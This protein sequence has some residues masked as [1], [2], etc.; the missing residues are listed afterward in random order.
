[1]SVIRLLLL[2]SLILPAVPLS[3]APQSGPNS[4]KECSMCHFRWIDDFLSEEKKDFLLEF[5][6]ERVVASEMMCYSCHDGS[7]ADSRFRVWETN[8]HKAGIKPSAKVGIPEEYPL[9]SEGRIQCATCHTAHGV[10]TRVDMASAIFLREPNVNSS[11]CKRCHR[12]KDDGVDEGNHPVDVEFEALPQKILDA[13]AKAGKNNRVICE[14]CHTAHGSTSENFLVI[15]NSEATL[16][17]SLL[18]ETCHTVAPDISSEASLR[19]HSHPVDLEL[20][21]EASLPEHWYNGEVPYLGN[22]VMVNCRTCHSPHNGT[23]KNHLLVVEREGSDRLCMTCHTS[24]K[25]ILQTKHDMSGFYPEEKNA[26]GEKASEIGVCRSCH[27]MHKGYGPKMWARNGSGIESMDDLCL[28]CHASGKVAEKAQTGDH[29]HPTGVGLS[30]GV[31]GSDLPL[32]DSEG[33]KDPD[34]KVA[35]ASCHDVHQWAPDS[36]E[37]GGKRVDGD[38]LSSF[39]RKEAAQS[40]ELCQSCHPRQMAI[41]GTEHDLELTAPKSKNINKQSLRRSGV[42]GACHLIHNAT[43]EKLWARKKGVGEDVIEQLCNGCHSKGHLAEEKTTGEESHPLGDRA[44]IQPRYRSKLPLHTKSGQK[45][46][47]GGVTCASC[48]DLH[49]WKPGTKHGPGEKEIEG[50]RFNSFLRL[51]NDDKVTLCAACH[52][53]NA[54]VLGT[55]HDLRITAPKAKNMDRLTTDETGVCGTCHIVHNAWGNNLWS[56]SVGPG[57]NR[58]EALCDGCHARRQSASKKALHGPKHP[59]NKSVAEARGTLRRETATFYQQGAD[60]VLPLFTNEGVR[61]TE[62][63]ITCSTCHNPHRWDPERPAPTG[64]RN[65]EGDGGNSFLRKSNLPSSGLCTLCHTQKANVVKTEHDMNLLA[66]REKNNLKQ[67]VAQSGVCSACHVPHGAMKGG[68]LLWSRDLGEGSDLLPEKVCLSCHAK[69]KVGG[70]KTVEEF[71]HPGEV[72]VGESTRQQ[73]QAYVPIYDEKGN[74]ATAGVITCPTCHNPHDWTP[75]G[76]KPGPGEQSEGSSR[77]S[78]LRF[79]SAKS[80]CRDCHGL[81]SLGRYKYYHHKS[82]RKGAGKQLLFR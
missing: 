4:S 1:M 54:L 63:D 40:E 16:T 12:D 73:H 56:R 46:E 19:R 36:D 30:P 79:K 68:Y 3:A 62:G 34:G 74:K 39:L 61:S 72:L 81:D 50:D 22:G 13:G 42:C 33:K 11:M 82:Q 7:I 47:R 58:N 60:T 49:V 18:C 75:E 14:T 59:M 15:P 17:H 6:E 77:N 41:R 20:P 78:F 23:K 35:C 5:P 67:T 55:D 37:R 25:K 66:R 57:K 26:E 43:G 29:T 45:S 64:K 8:K 10:D 65:L 21:E 70:E 38:G 69:G 80:V 53:E 9:D 44:K 71:S 76:N 51:P 48:H 27:F 28:S 32:F 52:E 24:K 31:D 2:L